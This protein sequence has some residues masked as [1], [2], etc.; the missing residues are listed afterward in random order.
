MARKKTPSEENAEKSMQAAGLLVTRLAAVEDPRGRQG[1]L[2]V[3]SDI[4]AIL[5][6]GTICGCDDA[7]EL[8]DWG[9]HEEAW[10]KKI[11]RL[12][13][14]IP[15]QDTY[16]RALAS[17]KPEAFREVFH[18]WTQELW[19]SF[20][21]QGQLAVDG[22][23]VRGS[24]QTTGNKSVVHMVSALCCESGLVCGQVRT[25]DKTN[26]V[27]TF[28]E[29]LSMLQL[30]GALVSMDAA[31]CQVEI[32]KQ[33]VN[34]GGDYLFGLKG[35]QPTL[36][37]E[38]REAF[39]EAQDPRRRA[40]EETAPPR[41][42]TYESVDGGHGRVETRRMSVCHDFQAW[43]PSGERFAGLQTLLMVESRSESK[44][45]G[46]V[47]EETRYYISSRRMTAEEALHA[48][49]NHW[50]VENRLHWVLDVIFS[51]DH[52]RTRTA[53]AAENLTV[54]RHFAMNILRN[55]TGDGYSLR[56]R[57]RLCNYRMDYRLQVLAAAVLPG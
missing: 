23:T 7:E 28:P 40:V 9:N 39:A 52:C 47:Q 55:Y 33:I 42:Q 27:G 22:K 38:V 50:H 48:V 35:N 14:G 53:Y 34:S 3:F 11:L 44:T 1:R 26:E 2:H 32:A 29:L 21:L 16:L 17:M 6:L 4:L 56:R 51:E 13:A 8:E 36:Q 12:P 46:E 10:L 19:K 41:I 37:S 43:V 54:V 5:V 25:G 31:G 49:R 57:R 45:G 15:S 18:E 20:G 24:R 30:D